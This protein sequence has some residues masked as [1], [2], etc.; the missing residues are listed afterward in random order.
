MGPALRS[1]L[2]VLPSMSVKRI[3][4]VRSCPSGMAVASL[5]CTHPLKFA[6]HRPPITA[7]YCAHRS[8][9]QAYMLADLVCQAFGSDPPVRIEF[10]DGSGTGPADGPAVL[11]VRRDDALRRLVSAPGELGL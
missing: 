5:L 10:P 1:Q 11:V 7:G 2:S 6:A 8:T 3:L 9:R 4:Y